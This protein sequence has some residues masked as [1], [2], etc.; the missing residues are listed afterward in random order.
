[1]LI[2]RQL[3]FRVALLL[4]LVGVALLILPPYK[5]YCEGD[6]SNQY[7]CAVYAILAL[8]ASFTQSYNGAITA[9]ATIVIAG[10]TGTLWKINRDQLKHGRRVERAY[11]KMSHNAPGILFGKDWRVDISVDVK[12]FGRTPARITDVL[13]S[14]MIIEESAIAARSYLHSPH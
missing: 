12:N 13:L 10:F 5:Q 1:M 4:L 2:H 9:V 14:T 8:F 7:G 3:W 6:Y 11:V